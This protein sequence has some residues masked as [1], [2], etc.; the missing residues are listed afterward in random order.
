MSVCEERPATLP[1]LDAIGLEPVDH[2]HPMSR[3]GSG[4]HRPSNALPPSRQASIGLGFTPSALG[5]S[6]ANNLFS[7][8]NFGTMGTTSKLCSGALGMPY[9]SHRLSTIQGTA[10]SQNGAGA[11]LQKR[12]HTKRNRIENNMVPGGSGGQGDG[13]DFY[14]IMNQMQNLD[15]VTPLQASEN[16]WD[17]NA[18]Q[19]DQDSPELVERKV[20]GL[21]NKLTTEK[22]ALISDQIIAWANLSENETDG[23][24]LIQVIRLVFEKATDEATRSEMYARLCRKMMEQ[25]SINFQNGC[26]RNPEGKLITGGQL[27]RKYLLYRCQ[28]EFERRWVAKEAT[29]AAAVTKALE[30]EAAKATNAKIKEDGT[31]EIVLY[32]DEHYAAQKAKRQGLGLI[33]FIG[34]LFKLQMLTERIMHECVKKLLGNVDNPEK[35]EIESLC[36]LLATVGSMLDIQKARGHLDVYFSRMKELMKSPNVSP[37]MQYMLQVGHWSYLTTISNFIAY[38]ICSSSAKVSGLHVMLLM[39]L[40][41]HLPKL[42]I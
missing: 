7:M 31:D 5:K 37:Q 22:F 32:S 33:K 28:E 9:T 14:S 4:H 40:F 20:K 12:V 27:F 18:I 10:T 30:D 39:P 25:I 8:G 2:T 35:E 23:R 29:A 41:V 11:P 26:I 1:P 13:S 34:E 3:G 21:L 17:R 38:R 6:G 24:T 16:L 42:V 15:P 19:N 36:T